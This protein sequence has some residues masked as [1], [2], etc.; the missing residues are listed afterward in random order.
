[1]PEVIEQSLDDVLNRI[2]KE[3]GEQYYRLRDAAL[4]FL[5]AKEEYDKLD[6]SIREEKLAQLKSDNS[7]SQVLQMLDLKTIGPENLALQIR[8]IR[9]SWLKSEQQEELFLKK[10]EVYNAVSIF[11]KECQNILG[12]K[13]SMIYVMETKDKNE[14][15]QAIDITNI[16]LEELTVLD[17][18]SVHREGNFVLRYKFSALNDDIIKKNKIKIEDEELSAQIN[19]LM[20]EIQRRLSVSSLKNSGQLLLYKIGSTKSGKSIW[21]VVKINTKGDLK[22]SYATLLAQTFDT[23][24]QNQNRF[25]WLKEELDSQIKYFVENYIQNV[26]NVSGFF[27]ED[28][29][30]TNSS[31]IRETW[32]VK[33]DNAS[34]L[35]LTRVSTFAQQIVNGVPSIKILQ[36]TAGKGRSKIIKTTSKKINSFCEDT[37][38]DLIT[39]TV[40]KKLGK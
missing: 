38:K 21:N 29:T 24:N 40:E 25:N 37:A 6:R 28:I 2:V 14:P 30:L 16:P 18:Q 31:G 3:Q 35:A 1:M 4:N 26:D 8:R 27:K 23:S 5:K 15:F 13:L 17:Q 36:P 34:L 9:Q 7:I 32:G 22:E 10:I 39:K 12:Y 11:Q 19:R 20:A 33:S